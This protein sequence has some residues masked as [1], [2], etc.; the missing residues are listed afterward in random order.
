MIAAAPARL[1]AP[2]GTRPG[3]GPVALV[4]AKR[5]WRTVSCLTTSSNPTK[6]VLE[7]PPV[8]SVASVALG[9]VLSGNTSSTAA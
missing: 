3:A 9:G 7:L 4:M 5:F 2:S 1:T 6:S 8:T